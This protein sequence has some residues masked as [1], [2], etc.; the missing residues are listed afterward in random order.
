MSGGE[1][2]IRKLEIYSVG[3]FCSPVIVVVADVWWLE[4]TERRNNKRKKSGEGKK[5]NIAHNVR[6]K[7]IQI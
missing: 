3:A 6:V 2:V 5:E 1:V 4:G 7:V